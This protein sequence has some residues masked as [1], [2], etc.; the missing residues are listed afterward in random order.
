MAKKKVGI[1]S[2]IDFAGR[3]TYRFQ[4]ETALE[5]ELYSVAG[6]YGTKKQILEDALELYFKKNKMAPQLR[7]AAMVI[8]RAGAEK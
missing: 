2:L 6:K 7:D 4:R 1:E 3:S 8:L 5:L